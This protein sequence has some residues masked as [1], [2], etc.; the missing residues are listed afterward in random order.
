MKRQLDQYA[1]GIYNVEEVKRLQQTG[2]TEQLWKFPERQ[3]GRHLLLG[4]SL[5]EKLEEK[6]ETYIKRIREEG[7]DVPSKIVMA[8]A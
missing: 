6:L 5:E 2:E 4:D 8:A 1:T 7:E 3:Q